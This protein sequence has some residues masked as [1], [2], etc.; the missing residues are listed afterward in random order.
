M[1]ALA[2][3]EMDRLDKMLMGPKV[4]PKSPRRA[5]ASGCSQREKLFRI[6]VGLYSNGEPL[7]RDR[8]SGFSSRPSSYFS[9]RK[10]RE[11]MHDD[12]DDGGCFEAAHIQRDKPRS[13]CRG[14]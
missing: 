12:A 9:A 4:K 13:T 11:I 8:V 3:E 1:A 6:T 14:H 10:F 5:A 7:W 2:A